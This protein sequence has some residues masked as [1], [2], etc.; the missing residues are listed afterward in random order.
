MT[1]F[2]Q[3]QHRLH[4]AAGCET[5]RP[6][7]EAAK[8]TGHRPFRTHVITT[9]DDFEGLAGEWNDL[10]DRSAACTVFLTWEWIQAWLDVIRPEA[11]FLVVVVRDS[12]GRLAG[13][14]PFYRTRVTLLRCV[15]YRCLRVLGDSKSGSEYVNV[16][17]RRDVPCDAADEIFRFL[18]EHAGLWDTLWLPNMGPEEGAS[19]IVQSAAR[20]R[21]M[22][23]R[24]REVGFA[25]I[26]FD[27][28]FEDY[29]KS[30]PRKIRYQMR[31]GLE[32][33]EHDRGAVLETC[34]REDQLEDAMAD[35]FRLHQA[36]WTNRRE[37]GIFS[38]AMTRGHYKAMCLRMLRRGWLRLDRVMIDGKAVAA[39]IGFGFNG[40]FYELQRG[41][42]PDFPNIPAGLGSAVRLM[43]IRRSF[44]EGIKYYD[45]LGAF[46]EDKSRSGAER[47]CGCDL[48]VVR[49]SLRNNLLFRSN[50]WPTGRF[51]RFPPT[52]R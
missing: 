13:I 39:Q 35:L 3:G 49:P 21:G 36:R 29:L 12:N 48:L 32:R 25:R 23:C 7:A 24:S 11:K 38:N 42:D 46:T 19:R 20:S 22:R 18:A 10:L 9:R 40:V 41:F 14:G 51:L 8:S 30:L 33:L 34:E 17:V 28:T 47:L 44:T 50:S 16:I 52:E 45:F 2:L 15:S 31:R 5:A 37:K 43:V 26:R 1:T 4:S 6:A 27:G